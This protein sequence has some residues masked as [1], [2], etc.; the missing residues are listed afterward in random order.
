MNLMS[1]VLVNI[2]MAGWV[3]AMV[4]ASLKARAATIAVSSRVASPRVSGLTYR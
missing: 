4:R 3:L 2:W 1:A